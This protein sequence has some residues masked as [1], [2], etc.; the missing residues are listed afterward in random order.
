MRF[1]HPVQGIFFRRDVGHND[2]GPLG[3][4]H[5]VSFFPAVSGQNAEPFRHQNPRRAQCAVPGGIYYHHFSGWHSKN[6][7][8]S[9]QR[10]TDSKVWLQGLLCR[11]GAIILGAARAEDSGLEH[12]AIYL[13]LVNRKIRKHP[14]AFH[15]SH[16]TLK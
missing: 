11:F 5:P 2:L 6:P 14:G 8:T 3:G 9:N 4:Q 1:F 12:F 7:P 16:M 10:K 13:P 15:F